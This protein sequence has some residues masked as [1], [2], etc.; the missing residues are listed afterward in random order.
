MSEDFVWVRYFTGE[1]IGFEVFIEC[2][3]SDRSPKLENN[4][5]IY[6]NNEISV[7]HSFVA[8]T[9]GSKQAI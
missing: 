3:M 6:E 4:R 7:A 5:I 2:F 8:L 1:H 9:E